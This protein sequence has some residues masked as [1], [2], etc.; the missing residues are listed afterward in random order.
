MSS[1]LLPPS[2][3]PSHLRFL[4]ALYNL[5]FAIAGF[6]VFALLAAYAAYFDY[7]RHSDPSFRKKRSIGNAF[8][9]WPKPFAHIPSMRRKAIQESGKIHQTRC[10]GLQPQA[11][12]PDLKAALAQIRLEPVAQRVE[13]REKYFGKCGSRGA[14]M[15]SR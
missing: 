15:L 10:V 12:A 14:I 13:A 1:G 9:F 11:P 5:V 2:L 6:T 3:L 8:I 4:R 7:K